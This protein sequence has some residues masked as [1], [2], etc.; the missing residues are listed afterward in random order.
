MKL[1]IKK[2]TI[3]SPTS[4]LNGTIKDIFIVN[5]IIKKIAANIT[6]KA[7]KTIEQ[8]GLCIS[9]GWVDIFAHFCDPGLEYRETI[10]TGLAAAAAGGFT[11]VCVLPNNS[12]VTDNKSQVEYIKQK[13]T[14]YAVN[15]HPIGAITKNAEGK[16]LAEMYDM[17]NS[18]AVAFS[19]GI[20]SLQSSGVMLKALQ[21][22]KAFDGT[23]IQ[24]PDD[25]SISANGIV[26]EGIV[27]TQLGLPGKPTMAEELMVARDLKLA[28]YTDSKIHFT[29][30]SSSK[31]LEYIKRSKETGI[32]VTCSIAPYSLFFTDEDI[33]TYDTNLKLNP[34]LRT[35]K[36]RQALIKGIKNKTID[37]IASHHIPQNWDGKTCEFEYAK[38]GMIGLETLYSCLQTTLTHLHVEQLIEMLTTNNRKI[39]GLPIPQIKEGEI[40]C[41]TLFNPNTTFTFDETMIKSKSKNS[42]FIGQ[43]L[44][45]K[46]IGIINGDKIEMN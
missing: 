30:I 8:K 13:A 35:E 34:P 46:V 14:T 38:N 12:P 29:G 43:K 22:V 5:G 41:I 17:Q 45:G 33:K 26:N 10:E 6:E 36:D 3:V 2:A 37:C 31:S 20:N 1:L 39:V 40:A 32:K 19:D 16:E 24:L 23:I 42:A 9:I 11:D 25:K 21:Y 28:R 4:P 44:T 27:S 15:I 7:S 18:G